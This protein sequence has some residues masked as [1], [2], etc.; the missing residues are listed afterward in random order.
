MKLFPFF[1]SKKPEGVQKTGSPENKKSSG[2][3]DYV[4]YLF[5]AYGEEIAYSFLSP[6]TSYKFYHKISPLQSTVKKISTAIANLP[7][8]LSSEED[9]ENFTKDGEVLELLNKPS[10]LTTKKQFLLDLSVSM[11]L[12]REM[13]VI[14]RGNV[15][16]EPLELV[17]V[18]PYNITV[19]QDT[20]NFWPL[21]IQVKRPGELIT[22]FREEIK[23]RFR[24]FD[25]MG[26]NEL[27]P[28]ISENNDGS[29]I[30]SF[31]GVSNLTSLKDELLSYSASVVSNTATLKNAGRPSGIISPKDDSLDE[32][33][34][35]AI[36]ESLRDI[37][38]AYNSGRTFISPYALESL[39]P[40]W[41]PK[42]MDFEKLQK[43][44]KLSVWNLYSMPLPIV[45]PDGQKFSNF[46]ESQVAFY[47]EAVDSV[48]SIIS[49]GLKWML[50][51]RYEMEGINISFNPFEVP[52]LRRR[53]IEQMESMNKGNA[54]STNEIR[55][56]AGYEEI[57]G[58]EDIIIEANRVPLKSVIEGAS[59]EQP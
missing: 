13:W 4:S 19:T 46:S 44:V 29:G 39:F 31:R 27:F 26:M 28:Y 58:G 23:G 56:S 54:L 34:M 2:S 24:Y 40:Q 37:E 51:T 59:F 9:P 55:R 35:E 42:D 33:Q 14:A 17:F 20:T 47:D 49:D 12:T 7:L 50:S 11:M 53:A 18:H 48:W 1:K 36:R 3:F 57:E 32:D 15:N 5:N 41:K 8:I 10:P 45:S 38:G 21:K 52:A 22:F 6:L 30:N 25:K 16:F 43:N